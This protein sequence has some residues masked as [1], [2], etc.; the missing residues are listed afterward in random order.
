MSSKE[1][2]ERPPHRA[3]PVNQWPAQEVTVVRASLRQD[4]ALPRAESSKLDV[5]SL[6]H[7]RL[8]D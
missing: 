4:D 6:L 7:R 3:K 1:Q 8:D 2:P 5:A